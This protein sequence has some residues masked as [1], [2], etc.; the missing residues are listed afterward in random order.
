[1]SKERAQ[2]ASYPIR[3]KTLYV[4]AVGNR[5]GLVM[6]TVTDRHFCM[7]CIGRHH[8]GRNDR[9]TGMASD[10]LRSVND[11]VRPSSP[12]ADPENTSMK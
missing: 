12:I 10:S 4:L 11:V 8:V 3:Y 9:R 6:K 5:H 1:M 2:S 7:S